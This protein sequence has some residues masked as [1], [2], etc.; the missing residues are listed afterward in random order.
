MLVRKHLE[1]FL[2]T[3]T[4]L[5]ITIPHLLVGGA[6]GNIAALVPMP[7]NIARKTNEKFCEKTALGRRKEGMLSYR[8]CC[9][10]EFNLSPNPASKSRFGS[11]PE[12]TINFE[13]SRK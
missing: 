10:Y 11:K 5:Y 9:G 2:N 6:K 4:D 12:F 7:K 13:I 3:R 8:Q 1:G